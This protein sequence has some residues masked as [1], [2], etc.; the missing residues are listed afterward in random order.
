VYA[1]SAGEWRQRFAVN[2]FDP[3]EGDLNPRPRASVG[4]QTV[5]AGEARKQ[6]REL[7][8]LAVLAGLAVL[9]AEWWVY[10]RRVRL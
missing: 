5:E 4:N 6:P 9:L 1:A 3:A 10:N 7:W 2:L 8:K